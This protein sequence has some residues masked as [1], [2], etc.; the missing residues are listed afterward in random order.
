MRPTYLMPLLAL[1]ALGPAEGAPGPGSSTAIA[2]SQ[3]SDTIPVA[4]PTGEAEADR[5]AI[6]AAVDDAVPGST[7]LFGAGR[8]LV[9]PII[10]IDTPGV[11]LLGHPEG[12]VLRGCELDEYE[13]MEQ[14]FLTAFEQDGMDVDFGILERCG[15]LHI[16]GGGVTVRR[17]TFEQSRMG[18]I[19][20]C[21]ESE[22]V[23]RSFAGGYLIEGNTFQNT[24]NSLRA[25]LQSEEPTV[26]RGNVFTNTFHA[27]SAAASR[28][29]FLDNRVSVPEPARVPFET[30]PGFG[31][32]IGA[33][34]GSP[35]EGEVPPVEP[36]TGNVIAG[37]HVEGHPDAVVLFASPGTACRDN[38]IRDN[39]LVSTR[40]PRPEVWRFDEIWPINDPDDPTFV[41]LPLRLWGD[42]GGALPP[43]MVEEGLEP[44]RIEGTR[45][46]GNRIL[47]AD[48]L[49]I[50]LLN[51]SGNHLIANTISTIRVRNPY[52]GNNSGAPGG[53]EAANGSGMWLSPGSDEN[54]IRGNRFE[55]VASYAVYLE[56]FRNRIE[57]VRGTDRVRDEGR[58]NRII[59]GTGPEGEPLR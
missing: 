52:P 20:G 1:L 25:W 42:A 34:P 24:G 51:A 13:A 26:I 17:F 28:I 11:T 57:T 47:G 9:G 53:W 32:T 36:C 7:I 41:G 55:D 49:G 19:L 44:G 8:Y 59:E 4:A 15:N 50:Q 39:T 3:A 38:V 5:A 33:Y 54:E 27:L 10:R 23:L 56:G 45:V 21:C 29:H 18:I 43:E 35:V 37:N 30:H 48:G 31:I 40:V 14:D 22:Q 12:T 2:P 6:V 16:T 58:G 46:E